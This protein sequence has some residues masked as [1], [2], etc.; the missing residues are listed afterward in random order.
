MFE[1]KFTDDAKADL[2]YFAQAR[3]VGILD[4]IEQQLRH[5][6]M[7]ETKK[8]KRLRENP[9]ASYELRLDDVRVFYNLYEDEGVVDIIAIGW[10]EH[11]E[12]FI[13]GKQV[14]L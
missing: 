13:K 4:G 9:L 7:V 5:Q 3:Q 10:K 8:R 2:R 6:P 11:N 1:V 14:I 12:L